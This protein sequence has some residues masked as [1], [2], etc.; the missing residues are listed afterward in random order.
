MIKIT[1]ELFFNFI[2]YIIDDDAYTLSLSDREYFDIWKKYILIEFIN[3]KFW[4]LNK[5]A[6][7]SYTKP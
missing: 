4:M 3:V 1:K 2:S 6:D 5:K 7:E